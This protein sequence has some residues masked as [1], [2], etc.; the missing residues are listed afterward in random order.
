MRKAN[1]A[2]SL[3]KLVEAIRLNDARL[4][5]AQLELQG[6]REQLEATGALHRLGDGAHHADSDDPLRREAG[7]RLLERDDIGGDEHD[8]GLEERLLGGCVECHLDERDG[9]GEGGD[10][11]LARQLPQYGQEQ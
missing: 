2:M 9:D 8:D 3:A 7:K 6:A 4:S 11:G 5:A 1:A 10:G